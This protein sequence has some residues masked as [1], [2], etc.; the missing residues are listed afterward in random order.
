MLPGLDGTGRLYERLATVL[1]ADFDVRLIA[2][3]DDGFEGYA[4]LAETVARRLPL[5]RPYLIVAESFAGP[6]AVMLAAGRPPGLEGVVIAASFLCNP[7]AHATVL[8]RLLRLLPAWV[9]PP[10][11][12][13]EAML[14]DTWKDAE[15]RR[16]LEASLRSAGRKVLKA[17]L[18]A[19]LKVD[20]R[21]E[22]QR[23]GVPVLYLWASRDRLLRGRVQDDFVMPVG[24][25]RRI[26]IEAPHFVFQ[27]SP[28]QAAAALRE[29]V[30]DRVVSNA[31]QVLPA[32]NSS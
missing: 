8:A 20:V 15:V 32:A 1:A 17:R 27:A 5:D 3:P 24:Q 14:M 31:D 7:V 11:P 13:L 26:E 23:I 29:F 10:L 30:R 2:Y 22:F 4:A 12:V 9:P 18:I 25:L 28:G 19:A 16:Q 21:A 6:L